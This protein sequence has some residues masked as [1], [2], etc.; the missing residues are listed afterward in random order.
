[1]AKR[2]LAIV[3]LLAVC[4]GCVCFG[5]TANGYENTTI[6]VI[7][8][9]EYPS[10]QAAVDAYNGSIIRLVKNETGSVDVKKDVYLDL[11]GC[12]VTGAVTVSA[13]TL[14]C[15]DTATDDFEIG[16]GKYGKLASVSGDVQGI[17]E[18]SELAEDGYLKVTENDGVSFH[19][20]D[21]QLTAISLR[22]VED[23][24]STPSVYYKCNFK[25]DQKVADAVETYGVALNT[26]QMPSADNLESMCEYSWFDQFTP[27]AG[28]NTQNGTLLYGVMKPTNNTLINNRNANIPIYGRAYIKTQAGYIFG[29]GNERTLKQVTEAADARWG[30]LTEDQKSDLLEMYSTYE[31]IMKSWDLPNIK[32][33]QSIDEMALSATALT[34]NN[35][36]TPL[37]VDTTPRFGWVNK[38][39]A[40]GRTQ[41]AYQIIVAS[42]KE[43]AEAGTGDLWDTGKVESDA[44]FEIAYAGKTLTSRMDCYWAV[45]VWDEQGTESDWTKVARFGMGILDQSDW[46]AK[47]IGAPTYTGGTSV[48][49][50]PMLRKGFTLDKNVKN[51]KIYIC[52]L[53]LF[54]LKVNGTIPDDSVLN[55]ADTQYQET[56]S[57]CAYD[58]TPLLQQGE[59][60]VTVELGCGFYNLSTDISVGFSSG[61]WKDDPKLL[62]ELYVEYEDGSKET[63]VSDESWRCY[64]DGPVRSDNIYC[65]EVYDA[66][67]EV[68]GWT[69]PDFDDS[70]W[71]TARLAA[72]PTG[73]LK[74]ENME[75]MRRVRSFMPTVEQLDEDTWLVYCPEYCTGWARISFAK[76]QK[77]ESIRIR[78]FQRDYERKNG[79]TLTEGDEVYQLQSYTYIAKGVPGET[80]EPKFSYAGYELIEIT[81]YT[82]QLKPEDIV[83]YTVASDVENIGDFSSGN[84]MVNKLHE[85]MVRTMI[86]NMQGKPT[87]TPIFEKLGWT[88]DYNG[89]I[90]TFNYNF[91]VS[92]FLGHFL[93][94]LRDTSKAYGK[95]EGH[96]I[97]F[98]PAGHGSGYF[99]PVWTQMYVNSIYA[100]WHE[101]GQLSLVEEHYDYMRKNADYYIRKINGGSE[102]WIWEATEFGAASGQGN[103]LGDWAAPAFGSAPT[104][105]PEG[106]SLYN[107]AAVYRV[108]REMA[109]ICTAMGDVFAAEN[110]K[111][112]ADNIK[113]NFN[114]Y[115]YNAEKGYYESD[116]RS[117]TQSVEVRSEYRQALNLVALHM[118][119]TTEENHDIVL[120]NLIADIRKKNNHADVGSVG[121]ELILP[122][123]TNEGY[124][125]LALE[126]LLQ[127][128][129]PSWGGW[130]ETGSTT[131]LEGWKTTNRSFCH[132][133]LG[134]YDEWF[135]QNL[136][137]I[138]DPRDGYKTVTICPEIYPELRFINASVNT[139]R[140]ELASSWK[141]D[142]NDRLTMTVTVPVGTTA[143]I[144][145]P[146]PEGHAVT[147]NDA[148]L[149]Q[150]V[151]VLEIGT[152]GDRI[153]VKVVG[154]T[155]RFDLGTDALSK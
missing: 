35:L 25:G 32:Y 137:G 36:D 124:H 65:G 10:L 125:D 2:L 41:S 60:A 117:E 140:G 136:G 43:L 95:E 132:Y 119:F 78:Y 38:S 50:A 130:I 22:P 5:S 86:C 20:V 15:K 127:T 147:L 49:P 62:L 33:L 12:S 129:Y 138:R 144:L 103:M 69:A 44:C 112:A 59:N 90:K 13:G 122:V 148:P 91:D 92:N 17:P 87:D 89:T 100:A 134:T 30:K 71:K 115:Y 68:A 37:G 153:L 40:T 39:N 151:G 152:Q 110:Y 142:E 4:I 47:W 82:G 54:E 6:A 155:Y 146:V 145:L 26:Q 79:L 57:Y 53:G 93:Y 80:Y 73:K 143:D 18:P 149:A 123:L 135:Y 108:M 96:L 154:G 118:G 133:F 102:P 63:V 7:G 8:S 1:M 48:I 66:G 111:V 34:V 107:T 14:Y 106:G 31:P 139:V 98:A 101:N 120:Q 24:V 94:N 9:T 19:R 109:E 81:G 46:T 75:P 72:A 141:V 3:C 51:A 85:A 45:K 74:Y 121:A 27:G 114:R 16:D 131:C 29:R 104:A 83:C 126:V 56:V 55:P 77:G 61:V 42:T 64:E 28:G 21:L 150:Q 58:V 99:A 23:G 11:N 128:D 97:E 52:G 84:V 113:A 67:K 116:Y 70:S 105:P 88:G 76:A